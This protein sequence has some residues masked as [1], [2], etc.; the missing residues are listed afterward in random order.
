MRKSIFFYK[1]L[2]PA[3]VGK[4]KTHEVYIRLSNDFNYEEFFANSATEN[5][6]V[7]DVTFNAIDVTD[8]QICPPIVEMRF[9]YF[10]NSNKEKR[11]PSLGTLF[12]SH[13]VDEGDIVR[14]ES[15]NINGQITYLVK[16]YKKGT[17]KINPNTLY[18]SYTLESHV[19]YSN[20]LPH[21]V[22]FYGA[23]GT[24][25][26]HEVKKM[27]GE[28]DG[29]GNDVERENV[30]RTTFHPDTDYATFVG[31]YK[32]V[33]KEIERIIEASKKEVVEEISYEFVPQTFTDAYIYAMKHKDTPTYLV[34]EEINRGNC[35]QIFGDL[36]Q[37][38]DRN[39]SGCSEYKIKPDKDL[40]RYL[41]KEL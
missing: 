11:I 26:S 38:L 33:M 30:F 6:S 12:S 1:E 27:T 9:A 36:F 4:A 5:G 14:L 7:I 37:L 20:N 15:R 2:T 18:I 41:A 16:F 21:Q 39:A 32:P 3:E 35:A 28:L 25:K 40:A 31:C 34:I 29:S 24:G 23:P 13:N 22:I 8:D 17:L 19:N 10:V